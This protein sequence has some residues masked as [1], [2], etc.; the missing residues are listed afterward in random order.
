MEKK[1]TTYTITSTIILM[2]EVNQKD[3]LYVIT[4]IESLSSISM[5]KDAQWLHANV[6]VKLMHQLRM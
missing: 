4:R 5:K 1:I 3:G 2:M 6:S